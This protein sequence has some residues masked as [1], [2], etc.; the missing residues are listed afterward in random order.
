MCVNFVKRSFLSLLLL[1]L[2]PYC[3]NAVQ[4]KGTNGHFLDFAG[5]LQAQP[6]G[7]L[8]MI[9]EGDDTRLIDWKYI[10]REHLRLEKPDIFAAYL[11]ATR[12][13]ETVLLKLGVFA[14]VMTYPEMVTALR[15]VLGKTRRMLLPTHHYDLMRDTSKYRN[16]GY[17]G[18]EEF[19]QYYNEFLFDLFEANY[20]GTQFYP[21]WNGITYNKGAYGDA[22]T[23]NIMGYLATK[24]NLSV[25]FG[26]YYFQ[27]YPTVINDIVD[28]L[29]SISKQV[30]NL[31][32]TNGDQQSHC[33]RL[34]KAISGLEEVVGNNTLSTDAQRD[35]K[36]F[37]EVTLPPL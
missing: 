19:G 26:I 22:P 2:A 33:F 17:S 11:K 6:D 12:E 7:L 18:Y 15:D 32:F 34:E 21:S 37:L 5:L 35:I 24:N 4:L 16:A 8:A 31:T 9:K 3:L 29:K 28:D 14:N 20:G 1:L 27:K 10:D 13:G 23:F 30:P 25:R 36:R